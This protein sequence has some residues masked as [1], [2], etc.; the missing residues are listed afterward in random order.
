ML[1]RLRV[2]WGGLTGCAPESSRHCVS[3]SLSVAPALYVQVQEL[4]DGVRE[5]VNQV[6]AAGGK[7]ACMILS[8]KVPLPLM[9]VREC[10]T[11][12]YGAHKRTAAASIR[13]NRIQLLTQHQHGHTQSLACSPLFGNSYPVE[14]DEAPSPVLR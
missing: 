12:T 6:H 14:E 1:R 10:R 13:Q 7:H 9:M 2:A 5:T 8:C 11:A 4:Y 3:P